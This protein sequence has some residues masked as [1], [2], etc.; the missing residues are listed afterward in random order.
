MP[1]VAFTLGEPLLRLSP[2]GY[3]L[4][5]AASALD[6]HVGG[7]EANVAVGLARL[8]TPTAL[9]ARLPDNP[10][11]AMA[12]GELR[13]A[14]VDIDHTTLQPGGRMGLYFHEDGPAPRGAR[15]VYDRAHS[16]MATVAPGD[17]ALESLQAPTTRLLHTTGI[18]LG[19]GAGARTL[20]L[21]G[22]TTARDAGACV[23]FDVN[24]RASLW[25]AATA[26][27]HYEAAMQR[28]DIV[29]VAER[30]LAG[31]WPALQDPALLRRQ[32]GCSVLVV[33]RGGNGAMAVT[34]DGRTVY[35]PSIPVTQ[36][37]GRIGRGDAFAAGFLHAWLTTTEIPTAL[38][39]GCAAAALK[40]TLP[41]DLPM[42]D[43]AAVAT[44]AATGGNDDIAR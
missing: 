9:L 38:A 41:G 36:A 3:D 19:I 40:Y 18:T 10:L 17:L 27:P 8:G 25:D 4:L 32:C 20:A 11:G 44:L 1:P 34:T 13:R 22:M 16:A 23:S 24:H 35:Q 43:A 14:G 29:I 28:A 5:E 12:R 7:A 33:T 2:P 37:A 15:V 42:F 39:W 30:D 21:E 6:V 31:I 26:R